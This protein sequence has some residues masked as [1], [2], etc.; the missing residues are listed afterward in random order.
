MSI[1]GKAERETATEELK[2][3]IKAELASQFEG[4]EKEIS[5]AFY[6]ITKKVVRRKVCL[7][8]TSRCV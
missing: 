1:A 4:R 3:A 8:Y 7:L 5:G 6:A 2:A